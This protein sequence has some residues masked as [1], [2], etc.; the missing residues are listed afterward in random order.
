ML[1]DEFE[2]VIE[3]AIPDGTLV[4]YCEQEL[5]FETDGQSSVDR[6]KVLEALSDYFGVNV[7]SIHTDGYDEVGVWIVYK[8]ADNAGASQVPCRSCYNARFDDELTDENDFSSKTI[9]TADNDYRMMYSSGYGKPPRLQFDAWNDKRK[10]WMTVGLYYPKH[11]PEC[12]RE[13]NE[14]TKGAKQSE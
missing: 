6:N 11:C 8:D 2:D 10:E 1:L 4:T 13:I 12:G 14:Y 5:F 7:T 9:G 3:K